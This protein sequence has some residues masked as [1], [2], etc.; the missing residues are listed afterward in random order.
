MKKK[1][2]VFGKS[3]PVLAIFVLGI[4]VVSAATLLT[5]GT[6]TGSV[7]V[8]Q[9]VEVT[10]DT[11]SFENINPAGKLVTDCGF[12]VKNNAEVE[13]PVIFQTTQCITGSTE[14]DSPGHDEDG[15][16]TEIVGELELTK[17]TVD[18]NLDVWEV[19]GNKVQIE[20][21]VVGVEFNAEVT[22]DLQSETDYVLVYYA[23]NDD[24]FANPGQAVLVEDV[25]ENL[26]GVDDENADLNDYSAEYP[27][28]PFGAKIWYVPLD[29]LTKVNGAY[30]ID[31]NR[32]SEFYFESSLIQYNDL[33]QITVYPNEVLDFCVENDFALNLVE[34]KYTITVDIVPN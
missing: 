17:K 10:G 24:R 2:N 13:A 32:A 1:V 14:C 26:P 27:T 3:I 28:T 34:H 20:Y 21:T 5:Y 8:S 16:T 30:D 23:D 25:S 11:L 15:I 4:A 31:W 33:G 12:S 18:F 29:A 19:L 9:A 7:L 22:E 6:I